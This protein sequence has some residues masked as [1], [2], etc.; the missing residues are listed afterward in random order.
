M[1][2]GTE[3]VLDAV[4]LTDGG[5]D[6]SFFF[7]APLIGPDGAFFPAGARRLADGVDTETPEDWVISDFN[8]GPDNTPTPGGFDGCSPIALT[9]PQIQGDGERSP[10][11]GEV[12]T[13]TGVVTAITSGGSDVWLQDPVGDGDPMT[14]DGVFL[15]GG[16]ALGAL[17]GDMVTVTAT[18]EEQQFGNA[19]PLTRLA[20]PSA[21]VVESS[22]NPL[23]APVSL[24]DLPDVSI[25]EGIEFWEPLEG[26]LVSARSG[27]V[28]APTNDFGEF[29]FLTQRDARPGFGLCPRNQADPHQVSGRRPGRLQPGAGSCRRLHPRLADRGSSRRQSAID[30]GRGRLLVWHLQTPAG[31]PRSR[32]PPHPRR[33]AIST[34]WRAWRHPRH[35]VQCGELVRSDR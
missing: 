28:V 10:F 6:D 34:Q 27:V 15:A 35:H 31:G 24:T 2:T 26:M 5:V 14:S 8:L 13:T 23:P 32:C 1:V 19:L 12:A 25:P 17:P 33:T 9:I 4:A 16:G 30:P 21:V 7:D 3:V 18:V 11:A 22:G 20:N 29:A